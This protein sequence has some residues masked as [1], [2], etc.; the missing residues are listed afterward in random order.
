MSE[1]FERREIGVLSDGSAYRTE[2]AIGEKVWWI[3]VDASV[4]D[5]EGGEAY[6]EREIEV[7]LAHLLGLPA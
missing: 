7:A 4:V 2:I 3:D 5:V 6:R 1:R